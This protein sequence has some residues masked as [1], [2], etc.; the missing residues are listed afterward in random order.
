MSEVTLKDQIRA[1]AMQ[2]ANEAAWQRK[3]QKCP[4]PEG[5]E[6]YDLW[7]ETYMETLQRNSEIHE[8]RVARDEMYFNKGR[9]N[10][11]GARV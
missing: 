1:K 9:L 3:N 10:T 2:A 5:T 11:S 7:K 4:F 6:H 8:R